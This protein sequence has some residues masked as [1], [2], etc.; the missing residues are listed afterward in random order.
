MPLNES[1]HNSSRV[2]QHDGRTT[3]IGQ[4]QPRRE[5]FTTEQTY[6]I[7]AHA[8]RNLMVI[9]YVESLSFARTPRY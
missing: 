7:V 2:S 9:H 5:A 6:V 4:Q 1:T 8:Y 3:A